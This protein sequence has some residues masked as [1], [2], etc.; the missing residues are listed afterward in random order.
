[1]YD[2]LDMYMILHVQLLRDHLPR[3]LHVDRSLDVGHVAV[4]IGL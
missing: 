4:L 3:R 1:M 2:M